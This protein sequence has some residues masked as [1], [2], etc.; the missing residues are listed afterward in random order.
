ME[1]PRGP[2]NLD[3]TQQA[4]LREAEFSDAQREV[5]EKEKQIRLK[6][7]R[8]QFEYIHNLMR[9]EGD[10]KR[11]KF[12]NGEFLDLDLETAV[13]KYTAVEIE[14]GRY[15]RK[16]TGT[17]IPQ[18]ENDPNV[19]VF[20]NRVVEAVI[21]LYKQ[22]IE[23]NIEN[24]DY[25]LFALKVDETVHSIVDDVVVN[26]EFI[27]EKRESERTHVG[28]L[29]FTVGKPDSDFVEEFGIDPDKKCIDVHFEA[30]FKQ[31]IEPGKEHLTRKNLKEEVEK[32]C[33]QLA[34]IINEQYLDIS[35]ITGNSWLR[36][37]SDY[38]DTIG[39]DYDKL[40]VSRDGY[41]RGGSFWGQ[42]TT[43]DG[44]FND[45]KAE[46]LING[47]MPTTEAEKKRGVKPNYHLVK[48]GFIPREKFL[49]DHLKKAE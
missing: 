16:K 18:A 29:N 11:I 17:I 26:A 5:K 32:S 41:G 47:E 30:L 15:Y 1:I 6:T 48:Y 7:Y 34:K 28:V 42:F 25:E 9:K 22:I 3:Q 13:K 21:E 43:A 20:K 19:P 4:P 8:Y 31:K 10:P 44:E 45:E 36:N 37:L 24:P 40:R 23:Q 49:S 39:F 2:E 12:V 46:K 38:S 14:A 33:Q 27:P 35:G